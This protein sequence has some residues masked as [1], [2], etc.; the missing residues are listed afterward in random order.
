MLTPLSDVATD[1]LG[2]RLSLTAVAT[3]IVYDITI[4]EP[5][6][7]MVAD[8][9]DPP[10]WLLYVVDAPLHGGLA[11][12]IA[13]FVSLWLPSVRNTQPVTVVTVSPRMATVADYEDYLL[14]GLKR[15]LVPKGD[16]AGDAS[17]AAEAFLDFLHTQVDPEVRRRTP[18][19]KKKAL[20]FGH[21]LS[22]L[23]ACHAFARQHPMFDR[24]IIASPT[25]LDGS[26]TLRAIQQASA[27]GL[28]GNLYLAISGEDRLDAPAPRHEGAVGRSFHSI[29][30]QLGK[31][32]RPRL[33]A[34]TDILAAESFGSIASAALLNGLRWHLPSTG[35][36][37]LRMVMRHLRGYLGVTL[38][39]VRMVRQAKRQ[40]KARGTS[41]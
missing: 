28:A 41:A 13:R 23:F 3:G 31:L 18:T 19:L 16:P 12:S 10:A 24:Y 30:A 6:C 1:P 5:K 26:P 22:G 21:G 29:A 35:R 25:L 8:V 9:P 4:N 15:D 14:R 33:R 38:G 7:L 32:H 27:G 39:M 36:D 40:Q 37:G 2:Q 20:L 17:S 11:T 34:R